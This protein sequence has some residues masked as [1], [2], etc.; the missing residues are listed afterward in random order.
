MEIIPQIRDPCVQPLS[1]LDLL[2]RE[3]EAIKTIQ[4]MVFKK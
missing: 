1:N 3:E 2:Q 4:M